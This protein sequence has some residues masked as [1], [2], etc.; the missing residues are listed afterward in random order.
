V[1]DGL[2]ADVL[3]LALAYDIDAVAKSRLLSADWQKKLPNRGPASGSA[4][5]RGA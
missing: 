1:I 2:E 3:T 5:A 4:C